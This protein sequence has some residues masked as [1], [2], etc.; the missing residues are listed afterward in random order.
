MNFLVTLDEHKSAIAA[1][2]PPQ[3]I[4]LS[5]LRLKMKNENVVIINILSNGH[6][7]KIGTNRLVV[8]AKLRDRYNHAKATFHK[9]RTAGP[10]LSFKTILS[11]A[12]RLL[13]LE[14]KFQE[15]AILL[16]RPSQ[17][18]PFG[19]LCKRRDRSLLLVVVGS[20]ISH[21]ESWG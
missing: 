8:I 6:Q 19:R 18:S 20:V 4:F 17:G 10:S 2:L 12:T 16:L 15:G 3:H 9:A 7:P 13:L 5:Q 14:E 11:T 1:Y 21:V